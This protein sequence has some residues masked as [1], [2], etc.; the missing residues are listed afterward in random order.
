MKLKEVNLSLQQKIDSHVCTMMVAIYSEDPAEKLTWV[1]TELHISKNE[2]KKKQTDL[3]NFVKI[4]K[5]TEKELFMTKETA[6]K[7][8]RYF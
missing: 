1:R 4:I 6:E 7:Y 2:L 5:A 3:E 8:R